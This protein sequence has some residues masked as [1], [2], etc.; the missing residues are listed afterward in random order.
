MA[1][2]QGDLPELR[3]WKVLVIGLG[4]S[5]VSA[6]RFCAERGASVVAVDE[7]PQDLLPHL[8]SLSPGVGVEVRG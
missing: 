8:D 3:G 4:L 5:G 6:A 1:N 2:L 7:R